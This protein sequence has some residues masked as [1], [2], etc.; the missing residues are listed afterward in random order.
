MPKLEISMGGV[1]IGFVYEISIILNLQEK[2]AK[3]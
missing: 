1:K 2:P 3:N